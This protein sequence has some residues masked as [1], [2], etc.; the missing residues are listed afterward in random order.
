MAQNRVTDVTAATTTR[1]QKCTAERRYPATP[2][3]RRAAGPPPRKGESGGTSGGMEVAGKGGPGAMPVHAYAQWL[4]FAPGMVEAGT[5]PRITRA[6]QARPRRAPSRVAEDHERRKESDRTSLCHSCSKQRSVRAFAEISQC[7][8]CLPGGPQWSCCP[9]CRAERGR[10]RGTRPPSPRN[11]GL[12][13]RGRVGD[14]ERALR[15]RLA[16]RWRADGRGDGRGLAAAHHRPRPR[17]RRQCSLSFCRHRGGPPSTP[18][19]VG[20][21]GCTR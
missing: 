19:A 12:R 16:R 18:P 11:G 13:R 15:A 9:R 3:G 21:A 6:R 2:C 4:T 10:R 7:F 1:R 20:P 8:L 5:P 14:R 17:P